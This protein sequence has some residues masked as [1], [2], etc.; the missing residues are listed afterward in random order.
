MPQRCAK[1]I[2]RLF[3]AGKI[4]PIVGS[5]YPLER[6]ADALREIEE[7]RAIGKIVLEGAVASAS[8]LRQLAS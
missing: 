6:G 4:N 1:E 7:R 8:Q 5:T 2:N 3:E